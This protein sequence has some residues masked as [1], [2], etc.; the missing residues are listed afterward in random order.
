[1]TKVFG[2][3]GGIGSGKSV[4]SKE[5]I[6]RG[7]CLLD[8]DKQVSIIYNKPNKD[9]INYLK[10]IGLGKAT[11]NKKINKKYI[12]N[13]IFSDKN[14]KLKLE[15]YIFKII[16]KEREAFIRNQR[17]RKTNIIFLD[18]P[19]LFE[20]NLNTNFDYIISIISTKKERYKRLKKSKKTSKVLFNKI[21]KSQTSDVVRRKKSDIIIF[22][23]GT[24]KDY[25]KKI[26]NLLDEISK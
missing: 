23:N 14:I 11:I 20:S 2:I 7:I 10:K 17:K 21:I 13:V 25:L 6:K 22:N 15:N 3:T 4:F 24:M 16:R 1:M 5:V 18:V 8:S 26:N 12:S 9:F 19:L